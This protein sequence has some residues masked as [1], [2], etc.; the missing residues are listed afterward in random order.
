MVQGQQEI[1]MKA[2]TTESAIKSEIKS[3]GSDN[4]WEIKPAAHITDNL[5]RKQ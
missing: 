5:P 3:L 1:H 2:T 4:K